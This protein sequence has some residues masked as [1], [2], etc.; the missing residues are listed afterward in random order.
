MYIY[1][2]NIY[3]KIRPTKKMSLFLTFFRLLLG[4]YLSHCLQ[5]AYILFTYYIISYYIAL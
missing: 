1:V 4:I 3:T 5:Y 2:G